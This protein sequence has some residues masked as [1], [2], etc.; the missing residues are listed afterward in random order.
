MDT[1]NSVCWAPPEWGLMLA[2]GSSDGTISVLSYVNDRWDAK[3]I[4]GA[5]TLGCNAVTWSPATGPY[6]VSQGGSAGDP[7]N[8]GPTIK[9]FASG[10]CD[11]L[12]KIWK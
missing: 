1:V 12:V 9:R 10:G 2:A 8:A 3:K 4:P 11:N 7:A 5:H 6:S